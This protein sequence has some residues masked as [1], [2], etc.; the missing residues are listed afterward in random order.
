[1][2]STISLLL[3]TRGRSK[4]VERLFASL[5]ATT[6]RRDRVEVIIYADEDDEESHRLDTPDVKVTRIIGPRL[7]MG[8]Y[9]TACLRRSSGDIVILSNDDMVVRTPGWDDRIE[10]M[11]KG[12]VDGIYLSY[13][14]DLFMSK[15]RAT[16]P[17]LSRRCCDLLGDP[18]PAAYR[19]AF[20]DTHLFDLFKRLQLAGFDRIKYLDDVVFEH[21]HYRT[22]KSEYDE[23]YRK[24]GRF[25]DDFTFIGLAS[26][27][28]RDSRRLLA[29]IQ[30]RP[31]LDA[32][33]GFVEE[34]V[35]AGFV[36]ALRYFASHLLLD[37]ELPLGWRG[38][39]FYTHVGRYLAA[40]GLFGPLV[41]LGGPNG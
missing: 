24:R 41:R 38:F 13:V 31:I 8:G 4:L 35:P 9:N 11:H 3:P 22:G 39:L 29:A 10:A 2:D 23:T 36:S 7:T 14:N 18:F 26:R 15:R 20:I 28:S 34:Y 12:I 21:L 37:K 16:F 40:R 32:E 1:V 19:G 33:Q 6:A 30:G 17:I 27:R 5:A 25:D